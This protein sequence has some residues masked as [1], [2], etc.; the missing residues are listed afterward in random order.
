MPLNLIDPKE[1]LVLV[2]AKTRSGAEALYDQY[3]LVL[4]LAIFRIVGEKDLTDTLLEKTIV[5]IWNTTDQYNAQELPLLTW[6]L[7]IAKTLAREYV[8]KLPEGFVPLKTI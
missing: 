4:S 2:R 8:I 7:A 6:M 5:Q 3:A 1:L